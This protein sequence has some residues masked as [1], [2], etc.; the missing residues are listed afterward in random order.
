MGFDFDEDRVFFYLRSVGF[1]VFVFDCKLRSFVIF[2]DSGV[3]FVGRKGVFGMDS[4][5][6]VLNYI[7]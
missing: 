6:G 2:Y 1:I 4:F 3:V 5:F 7:K